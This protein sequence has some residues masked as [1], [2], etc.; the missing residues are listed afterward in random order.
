M[1]SWWKVEEV[2]KEP[3]KKHLE[4]GLF[5]KRTRHGRR[6]APLLPLIICAS[7]TSSLHTPPTSVPVLTLPAVTSTHACELAP[8]LTIASSILTRT[9]EHPGIPAPHATAP[10]LPHHAPHTTLSTHLYHII[11][12]PLPPCFFSMPGFL[13]RPIVL[14]GSVSGCRT[15]TLSGLPVGVRL[16]I[17]LEKRQWDQLGPCV[18][19]PPSRPLGRPRRRVFMRRSP[20]TSCRLQGFRL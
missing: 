8:P 9:L 11:P 15:P 7:P 12:R 1:E 20:L 2:G 19:T 6:H 18:A 4:A 14:P 10:L 13:A 3:G 17:E 5:A 16:L